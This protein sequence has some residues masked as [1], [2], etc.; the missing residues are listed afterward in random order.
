[1]SSVWASVNNKSEC[2]ECLEVSLC[3]GL[4]LIVS[5]SVSQSGIQSALFFVVSVNV[6]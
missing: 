5:K 2:R 1:M 6:E 4:S 3:L